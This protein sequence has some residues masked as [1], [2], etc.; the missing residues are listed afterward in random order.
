MKATVLLLIIF[1]TLQK[2][3]S[4]DEPTGLRFVSNLPAIF[5]L[6]TGMKLGSY[7]SFRSNYD[8]THVTIPLIIIFKSAGTIGKLSG[9]YLIDYLIPEASESKAE[10]TQLYEVLGE[11]SALIATYNL[12]KYF[13]KYYYPE[14]MPRL[15]LFIRLPDYHTQ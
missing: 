2:P 7:Y 8:S 10:T 6:V 11:C 9:R 5:Y 15:G 12:S 13:V 3:A 14:V 1:F 4:S